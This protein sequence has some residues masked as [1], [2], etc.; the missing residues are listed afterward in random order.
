MVAYKALFFKAL[1]AIVRIATPQ[2]TINL[3]FYQIYFML[4]RNTYLYDETNVSRETVFQILLF[5]KTNRL[6]F[7]L[8]YPVTT[9]SCSSEKL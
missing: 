7:L 8:L 3:G 1:V 5:T 6:D 4:E 9:T 2:I